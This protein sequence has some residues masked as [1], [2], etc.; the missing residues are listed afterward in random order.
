MGGSSGTGS[1]VDDVASDITDDIIEDDLNL[2]EKNINEYIEGNKYY[3]TT[4]NR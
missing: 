2:V 3:Q 4:G 1:V